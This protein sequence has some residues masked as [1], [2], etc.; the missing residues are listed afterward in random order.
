MEFKI[1]KN[2]KLPRVILSL[3]TLVFVLSTPLISHARSKCEDRLLLGQQMN[4]PAVSFAPG[5]DLR[6]TNFFELMTLSQEVLYNSEVISWFRQSMGSHLPELIEMLETPSGQKA[7]TERLSKD[8]ELRSLLAD[9]IYQKLEEL[10]LVGDHFPSS[11]ALERSSERLGVDYEKFSAL[12]HELISLKELPLLESFFKELIAFNFPVLLAFIN[13]KLLLEDY[14]VAMDSQANG[15]SI[16]AANA[17]GPL[18]MR[19]NKSPI[20]R[21]LIF[22][23]LPVLSGLTGGTGAYMAF[24]GNTAGAEMAFGYF[25]A[26]LASYVI[27]TWR[28]IA[29]SL[30]YKFKQNALVFRSKMVR[31]RARLEQRRRERQMNR[32]LRGDRRRIE[33]E[34]KEM[35]SLDL[36]RNFFVLGSNQF[37]SMFDQALLPPP[38]VSAK[39]EAEEYL[40]LLG[41]EAESLRSASHE[42]FQFMV[43]F[44]FQSLDGNHQGILNRDRSEGQVVSYEF[45]RDLVKRHGEEVSRLYLNTSLEMHRK[46]LERKTNLLRKLQA[47]KDDFS[48]LSP[49]AMAAV[50]RIEVEISRFS[51]IMDRFED[52]LISGNQSV[53]LYQYR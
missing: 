26:V 35:L 39:A 49:E 17:L 36:S 46:L 21:L 31:F 11:E 10:F 41:A 47:V 4:L 23:Y 7:L 6:A 34:I 12:R 9:L 37:Y 27:P 22:V 5:R 53:N 28:Q 20:A 15:L 40:R 48:P 50:D 2:V 44:L 45:G 24:M 52:I 25:G 43:D 18:N 38:D 3:F 1:I 32:L 30:K 13:E 19:R 42:S 14:L 51:G 8:R 29:G 16:Q 33:S